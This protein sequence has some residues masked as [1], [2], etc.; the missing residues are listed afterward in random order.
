VKPIK[1]DT[2]RVN[3]WNIDKIDLN[4]LGI[5]LR[6]SLK[7]TPNVTALPEIT[8]YEARTGHKTRKESKLSLISAVHKKGS[9]WGV[10]KKG[11]LRRS[12]KKSLRVFG[13]HKKGGFLMRLK[14]LYLNDKRLTF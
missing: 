8:P 12:I 13:V 2:M 7:L 9:F 3:L 10:Y 4:G 11:V 5:D 1:K 14:T 6:D